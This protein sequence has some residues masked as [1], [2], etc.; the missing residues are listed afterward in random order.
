MRLL[1]EREKK[2]KRV[3]QW[4]RGGRRN[5]QKK[6]QAGRTP[7][8]TFSEQQS[9]GMIKQHRRLLSLQ[10]RGSRMERDG[11]MARGPVLAQKTPCGPSL[12]GV[13]HAPLGHMRR[14]EVV[15]CTGSKR[16]S[17]CEP[18]GVPTWC[19]IKN[20]PA[21][22]GKGYGCGSIFLELSSDADGSYLFTY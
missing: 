3:R 1:E 7:E 10:Y 11:G 14:Q 15:Q 17:W 12:H 2:G 20:P 22:K 5:V 9:W 8:V 18:S 6:K 16:V 4:T 19:A 21:L 13:R